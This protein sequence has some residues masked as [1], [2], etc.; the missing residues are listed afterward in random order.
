M[1]DG[2]SQQQDP[3]GGLK[4][5]VSMPESIRVRMVEASSLADYEVWLF[6]A[7]VFQAAVT[8]FGIAYLQGQQAGAKGNAAFGWSTV[9]F[10]LL[11]VVSVARAMTKRWSMRQKQRE[12]CCGRVV[13]NTE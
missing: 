1:N 11:F 3:E 13:A 12:I 6:I 10:G 9:V 8:G 5:V 7:S 2:A 4:I